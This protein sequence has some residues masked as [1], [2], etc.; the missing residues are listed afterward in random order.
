MISR[1]LDWMEKKVNPLKTLH[2]AVY[3]EEQPMVVYD[4]AHQH[5][6]A[7][8][9]MLSNM[10]SN[11]Y[12]AA[13]G[14]QNAG[15]GTC[16]TYVYPAG[17]TYITGAAAPPVGYVAATLPG[18]YVAV[19]NGLGQCSSAYVVPPRTGI[20]FSF[21]FVDAAGQ[22][23]ML[24]I[25]QAHMGIFQQ[26]T[27]QSYTPA[28][29]PAPAQHKML[30]GDFSFDEMEVAEEIIAELANGATKGIGQGQEAG[31]GP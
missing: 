1:L 23:H 26:I 24:V 13:L 14:Q 6:T 19:G 29:Q 7:N 31:C 5:A 4:P 20:V 10:A 12:Q 25:D 15:V 21:G 2:E 30:E 8:Q 11:Q 22:H 28:A 9:I 27:A 16:G 18:G 3:R 17:G